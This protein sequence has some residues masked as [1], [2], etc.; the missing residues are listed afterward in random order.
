M[1]STS[2]HLIKGR[3]NAKD[4]F[5][6]PKALAKMHIDMIPDEY[7][8]DSVWLDPCANSNIYYDQFPKGVITKHRYEILE[9]TNFLDSIFKKS[10]DSEFDDDMSLLYQSPYVICSNPPYSILDDWF[11]K[12]IELNPD[13][14]SYLIGIGNLTARRI[15]WCEKAGYGLTKMKMLK[16]KSWYGMSIIVVFEKN[17]PS[18]MTIDRKVWYPDNE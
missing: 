17:K 12:T 14:F 13:C 7:I 8:Q 1:S 10:V 2:S 4:I 15:E 11:K 3:K 16:V 5:I 6:T 9:G 18:I